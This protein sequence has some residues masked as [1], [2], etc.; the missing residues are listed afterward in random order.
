M[1]LR[2]KDRQAL[3]EI[4]SSINIPIEVWAHGS[5]VNGT[6]H[7]GSDL[8]LVIRTPQLEKLPVEDF[9]DL[10]EKIQFSNI[11]IV[12]ELFD[13]AR[14]PDSFHRNIEALHEVLFSNLEIIAN[15]PLDVYKKGRD[16]K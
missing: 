6:A 8:D 15:E 5:R 11:P 10:K 7:E 4:F 14:L 9:M 12:V 16:K 13:W 3:I 2:D 1:L